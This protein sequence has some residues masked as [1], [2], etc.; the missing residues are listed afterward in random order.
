MTPAAPAFHA[1]VAERALLARVLAESRVE[2]GGSSPDVSYPRDVAARLIRS[3]ADWSGWGG[4]SAPPA[5][6]FWGLLGLLAAGALIF[7]L[8]RWRRGAPAFAAVGTPPPVAAGEAVPAAAADRAAW[9]AA[10]W[11]RELDRLLEEGS[12]A[13]ALGACWWWL[14]RSLAGA[15]AAPQWTGGD[16]LRWSR[17]DDLR[18]LVGQLDRL[19]Y[20]PLPSS[21]A[22]VRRLAG[23]LESSLA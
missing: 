23:R 14:A 12:A 10:A 8:R 13:E 9:N 3:T 16:L 7:V 1:A 11:R 4:W 15:R 22:E 5:W 6:L 18:S 20:G 21:L 19:R 17:R 2:T